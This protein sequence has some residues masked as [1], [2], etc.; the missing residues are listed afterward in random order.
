M[1]KDSPTIRKG[2]GAPYLDRATFEQRYRA[3][4]EGARYDGERDAVERLLEIAWAA[5]RDGEK[6]P[7]TRKAGAEF[8]DPDYEL[9]VEWLAARDAIAKAAAERSARTRRRA[10]LVC[11]SARSDQTCPGEMSKTWRLVESARSAIER[12]GAEC[13]VLDLSELARE[14]ERY[15]LPCKGCVSTA[16]PLCHWPCSCYPNHA[17]G[18]VNDAMNGLYP[19]FVAA[20]GLMFVTPVHWYQAPTV[21]KAL[22]DRL[23]CADGGNPDPTRT[24][25]KD[26]ERAKR[27]ELAGW[28]F[29]RHL[30][31]R[32]YAVVV[33]GDAQGADTLRRSLVDWLDDMQLIKAGR[34]AA[35]DRYIG[36]Y[37]PY[38]TS[39]DD[40]DADDALFVEVRHAATSLVHKMEA[41]AAGETE[42]DDGLESP[43]PK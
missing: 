36:Y 40:L 21:L 23:V 5:Y 42:P 25:G 1:G 27:I 6:S 18:Q 20:D 14:R 10:L 7:H 22:I 31:G 38:A 9:S 35:L 15:I 8:E 34:A 26:P 29:P 39:H 41:I 16:M 12:E 43:R 37:R 11:C 2:Q 24:Q 17:L 30:A 13:D 28:N 19:R 32:A 33:H 4:Y 3:R